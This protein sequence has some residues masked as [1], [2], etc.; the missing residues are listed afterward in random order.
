MLQ[1]ATS[2]QV[3]KRLENLETIYESYICAFSMYSQKRNLWW[4][5]I[6]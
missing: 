2:S 6:D 5:H 1:S 4:V 3:E